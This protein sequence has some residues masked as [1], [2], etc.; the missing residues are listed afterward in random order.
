MKWTI[1][2]LQFFIILLFISI[3]S[4]QYIQNINLLTTALII[5]NNFN[6]T[7]RKQRDRYEIVDFN[8]MKGKSEFRS[9]CVYDG[10]ICKTENGTSKLS[11]TR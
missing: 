8:V 1:F 4:F 7:L 5:I 6:L 11:L 10:V 2:V 3:Q 9:K